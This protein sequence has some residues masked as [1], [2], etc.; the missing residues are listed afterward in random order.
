[1]K[2]TRIL[3]VTVV[4]AA[5]PLAGCT[6][7]TS[8]TE[9]T[10]T[11]SVQDQPSFD[12]RVKELV[13]VDRVNPDQVAASFAELITTWDTTEDKTE[14]AAAMR[15]KPLMIKELAEKTVEPERNSSQ[16]LWLE[17]EPL[18]GISI[19]TVGTGVPTDAEEGTDTESIAY[20]NFQVTWDWENPEGK[21]LKEDPR[22][23]NVFLVLTKAGSTWSVADYVTED[24]PA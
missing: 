23:R 24:L 4:A 13:D 20:R 16:A 22:T 7:P 21:H 11:I 2:F 17:L 8:T 15:A 1:M 19:P 5:L 9:P 10:S 14:T 6:A 3:A 12:D 18:A